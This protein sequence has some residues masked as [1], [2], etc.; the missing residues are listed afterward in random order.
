M[1]PGAT[2]ISSSVSLTSSFVRLC[3][4]Y[5]VFPGSGDLSILSFP[6]GRALATSCRRS[7]SQI[8]RS[9]AYVHGYGTKRA[10]F[11]R[12]E[13]ERTC[14]SEVH[15]DILR[16]VNRGGS[17]GKGS[18]PC[19]IAQTKAETGYLGEDEPGRNGLSMIK[20]SVEAW[21]GLRFPQY[22]FSDQ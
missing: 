4:V 2:R 1:K 11:Q 17:N 6:L 9:M 18:R 12:K 7:L 19:Q 15:L 10:R 13:K 22:Q 3:M 14:S 5:K 21:T 20:R 16:L 8:Q